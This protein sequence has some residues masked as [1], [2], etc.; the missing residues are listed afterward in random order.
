MVRSDRPL[1]AV[2]ATVL[3]AGGAAAVLRPVRRPVREPIDPGSYFTSGQRRR[4]RRYRR[5][6]AATGLVAFAAEAG[7]M[8]A[9]A[10]RWPAP[11][12]GR[13]TGGPGGLRAVTAGAGAG[14]AVTTAVGASSLP[15]AALSRRR[16]VRVG[17]ATGSWALWRSDVVRSTAL[18]AVGGAVVGGGV[19]GMQRRW[20]T[21]WWAPAAAGA[22]GLSALLGFLA[23]VL[24]EPLFGRTEPL[25]EGPLL[26]GIHE[27]AERAGTPIGRVLVSD[28][29]RRTTAVNAY[30]SGY[31]RSRRVVLWDTLSDGYPV[32]QVLFVVAHELSHVAHRDVLRNLAFLA[33]IAPVGLWATA[34]IGR[35]W[36]PRD[37][38]GDDLADRSAPTGPG[39]VA[40]PGG[41]GPDHGAAAGVDA[42]VGGPA[43]GRAP[44]GTA[45]PAPASVP[46]IL[47]AG[48]V[49]G[50][51]VAPAMAWLS[52]TVE[53]RADDDALR[54][55][56]E[57]AAMIPFFQGIVLQ[58]LADPAP[59]GP[60]RLLG[61]LLSTHPPVAER[62]GAAV[63]HARSQGRPLPAAVPLADRPTLAHGPPA[64]CG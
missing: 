5:P 25:G 15:L 55:A 19:A 64:T 49:V 21:H 10:R 8:A 61:R 2:A 13:T 37:V 63:A 60:S 47:A 31:G 48:S 24:L 1:I 56:P 58:N 62:I 29:S 17:L 50:L 46:A 7:T 11:V 22:T 6:Q 42:S 27:V 39:D 53:R 23:P 34:A 28:A 44:A 54:W 41:G 57:P 12:V 38:A 14:A 59:R 43:A 20:P 33:A 32:E 51:V 40:D 18:S 9:L 16:A 35:A 3:A 4:A 45:A 30:V 52:R 26:E 36:T